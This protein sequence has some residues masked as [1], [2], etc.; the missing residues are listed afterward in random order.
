M[1]RIVL[2]L[3]VLGVA[4]S[5]FAQ[6]DST[7]YQTKADTITVGSMIIIRKA[8]EKRHNHD[9]T[10]THN[11]KSGYWSKS[12]TNWW[13]IDVGFANVRDETNYASAATQQFAPGSNS[14]RFNLRNGKSVNVNLWLFMQRLNLVKHYLNLKYGLGVE[15]N[16]YR[17]DDNHI[18]FQKNP[19]TIVYDPASTAKKNK[20]AADYVTLPAMINI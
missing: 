8:G 4:M 17:F 9:I 20:L 11:R 14:D 12:N 3:A 16:N 7:S 15:L 5:T 13:V 19:T 6:N 2:L 10:V 1:N 18:L